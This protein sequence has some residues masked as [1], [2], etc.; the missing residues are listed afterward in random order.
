MKTPMLAALLFAVA[1]L[2][3]FA[4]GDASFDQGVDVSALAAQAKTAAA[5]DKTAVT[6]QAW[7]GQRYDVECAAVTFGAND[8]PVSDRVWLRS[9]E[10]VTECAPVGDPRRGGGQQCWERPG[11]SWNEPI[12][13]TLQNRP[14]LLPWERDSFRVCLQGP[15][16]YVD[17]IEAAYDYRTVSGRNGDD[18]VLAAGRRTPESPDP[19]G[20]LADLNAQFKVSFADKWASNYAGEKIV[21]KME[22]KKVVKFWP[23]ATVL[24]K[25]AAFPV[26][27]SYGVD[28]NQFAAEFKPEAG[29][30]YYVK[31]SI[32][33]VGSI[34]NDRFTRALET[35][36]ISYAPAALA[37][38]R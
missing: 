29:K 10:W 3:V 33:R 28:L 30:Q 24:T 11:M 27:A 4:A 31:Y 36:K 21:L 32:K 38:A 18:I 20:V 12:Q 22:L 5:H 9:Q 19:V 7:G 2:P 1:A 17:T 26:A 37:F 25:E 13:I 14:A 16:V 35:G 15:W 34:S 6:A 8:K 23:D